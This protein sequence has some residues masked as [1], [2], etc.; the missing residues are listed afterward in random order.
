[1]SPLFICSFRTSRVT[2]VLSGKLLLIHRWS[3]LGKRARHMRLNGSSR[4]GSGLG[5]ASAGAGSLGGGSG[6][7]SHLSLNG[8]TPGGSAVELSRLDLSSS[9]DALMTSVAVPLNSQVNSPLPGGNAMLCG[10]STPI[11]GAP[12]RHTNPPCR[13]SGSDPPG[14]AGGRGG[15]PRKK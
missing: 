15:P 3:F 5:S 7:P 12:R 4:P 6:P 10:S 11:I 8:S 14:S 9:K 1:M 2:L 13:S